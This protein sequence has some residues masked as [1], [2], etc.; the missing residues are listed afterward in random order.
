[1]R[2]TSLSTIHHSTL[3][4]LSDRRRC[5]M[6]QAD[7]IVGVAQ[8]ASAAP[9]LGVVVIGRN[10]GSRLIACFACLP[11]VP[12]AY[13]DSGSTDGSV[14]AARARQIEVVELDLS[15]PFTAA[16]ARNAGLDQLIRK[17]ADLKYVQF[18]DGDC[19]LLPGWTTS[20]LTFLESRP[21]VAAVCGRLRERYPDRS[22]YN[23]LCDQEWDRPAGEVRSCAGNA[24][25]R[26]LALTD[27]GGY[28]E[29]VI[30][31]EEDELCVRL[32]AADWHIWRLADAM[33]LHDAAMLH[34]R[35]WWRRAFRAGYAFAQGADL[36]GSTPDR[37]FV[38]ESRRA[39]IWGILLPLLC[40]IAGIAFHP[41]G[42]SAFLIY[43]LQLLR[44]IATHCKCYG[45]GT[46]SRQ[47]CRLSAARAISRRTWSTRFF[48][49]PATKATSPTHRA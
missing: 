31:A 42:W 34:F 26:V 25:M 14:A 1:M 16:R 18:V 17:H 44:L 33:A 7:K 9:N 19:Q 22:I 45:I 48:T 8:H 38:W 11:N 32:R 13:V 21:D 3:L 12:V 20:A 4:V 10:E 46:R 24:M 15:I 28:R 23:W 35:Q 27:V 47:A 29:D 49:R 39:W 36:H 43:P 30:A 2:R 41:L 40:I 5:Q 6:D 37:H